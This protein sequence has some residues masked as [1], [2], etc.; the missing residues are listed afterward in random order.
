MTDQLGSITL[1]NLQIVRLD[2]HRIRLTGYYKTIEERD[3]LREQ[4]SKHTA[5]RV[6]ELLDGTQFPVD[7]SEGSKNTVYCLFD[8]VEFLDG[9]YL[10]QEYGYDPGV[11]KINHYPY[12]LVLHF[13]GTR[14]KYLRKLELYGFSKR[15]NYWD[16]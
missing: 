10:I 11:G 9:F 1:K 12:N 13:I 5:T 16:M 8:N 4:C 6:L 3:Q 14:S 15:T 7:L 2:S